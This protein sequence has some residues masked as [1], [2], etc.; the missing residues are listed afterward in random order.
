M[1]IVTGGAGFI[2]SN[3]VKELNR[4]GRTDILVV[5]NLER[6]EKFRNLSDLVIQDYMDK[7]A[8]RSRLDAGTFDLQADAILHNGACSDTMGGDGRYMLENNFGDSK[9]L[10]NYALSKAI[11]FVY[12]SSAATYG[13]GPA[14]VPD[15]ANERPLNVYGYSKLLFDQHVRHLLPQVRSTVVGLRYFNVYGPR[16]DHKGR[17]MSVL[18]QLL[19]QLREEGACRLFTGTGGYGDGEQ[20]RDF[21]FV[22][23]IVDIGLHFAQGP[24]A[25]GI[26]NAGTGKA[27]SFN[28][29]AQA[30]IAHLGKGRVDY[31]PF[32]QEL[33]GKYQSFTQADLTSLRAAG[34]AK[35]MTELEEGIRLTLAELG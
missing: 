27:R 23:D 9:A 4:R 32:P 22:G 31:I 33:A 28:A 11:P 16:E 12:A 6:S 19:R 7:R 21:V 17:M 10:L 2:G 24:V 35:P 14:F 5:D 25:Q 34:Y 26:F 15:P 1:I 18:H 30:L 13:P 3:V 29:I 8:F 20:V